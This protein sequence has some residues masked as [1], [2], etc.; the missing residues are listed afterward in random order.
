MSQ[1]L[2]TLPG[3]RSRIRWWMDGGKYEYGILKPWYDTQNDQVCPPLP[4]LVL[5]KFFFSKIFGLLSLIRQLVRPIITMKP[6][7]CL[8]ISKSMSSS[9]YCLFWGV[10][11]WRPFPLN[12]QTTEEQG[13]SCRQQQI[14]QCTTFPPRMPTLVFAYLTQ[15]QPTANPNKGLDPCCSHPPLH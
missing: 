1:S 4:R 11:W 7:Y 15:C 14:K 6:F 2:K 12:N 3:K 5:T 10:L 8:T 9:I 13:G